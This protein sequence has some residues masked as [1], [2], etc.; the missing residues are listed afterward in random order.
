MRVRYGSRN[1]TGYGQITA[2]DSPAVELV[3]ADETVVITRWRLKP[4]VFHQYHVGDGERSQGRLR[5]STSLS[6]SIAIA[7]SIPP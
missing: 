5:R 6:V 3:E 7:V 2:V 1:H 4:S